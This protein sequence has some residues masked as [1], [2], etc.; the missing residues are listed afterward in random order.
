M[1]GLQCLV[2]TSFVATEL[3][4]LPA[5]FGLL[6]SPRRTFGFAGD[7]NCAIAGLRKLL[8]CVRRRA[9][10][11]FA[12]SH[13]A[14]ISR[15]WWTASAQN[16]CNC[17]ISTTFGLHSHPR[18]ITKLSCQSSTH[19]AVCAIASATRLLRYRATKPPRVRYCP[20][21]D[22]FAMKRRFRSK[23]LSWPNDKFS[24]HAARKPMIARYRRM[25]RGR[26]GMPSWNQLFRH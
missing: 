24:R 22:S 7:R 17:R 26:P 5:T 20:A 10:F 19:R 18:Q 6:H 14:K 25:P 21:R 1:V 13:S 2:G 9:S 12:Y 8:S 16:Q 15:V 4:Q 3:L 11:E 23:D